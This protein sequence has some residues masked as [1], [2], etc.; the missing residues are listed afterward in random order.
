[1]AETIRKEY[2]EKKQKSRQGNEKRLKKK[3]KKNFNVTN[4]RTKRYVKRYKRKC[5]FSS[6]G[7]VAEVCSVEWAKPSLFHQ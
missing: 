5:L 2:E 7:Q 6:N 4:Q 3:N 1:M